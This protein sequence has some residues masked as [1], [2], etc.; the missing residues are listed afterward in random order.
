MAQIHKYFSNL[1]QVE[2]KLFLFI[3]ERCLNLK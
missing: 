1:I 2:G 3:N